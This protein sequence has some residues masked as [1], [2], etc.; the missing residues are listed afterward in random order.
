[1]RYGLI[2]RLGSAW[3]GFHWAGYN[4]RLCINVLPFVTLWIVWPG[5]KVPGER[6]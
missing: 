6:P 2:F 3:V 4:K 1:M 5:G